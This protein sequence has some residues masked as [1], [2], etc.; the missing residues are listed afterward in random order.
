[1]TA[2]VTIASFE[3]ALK[4]ILV[5]NLVDLVSTQWW[6]IT[7][8]TTE[9]NPLMAQ[10][11]GAGPA[12]FMLAKLAL[13]GLAVTLLWRHRER[14]MARVAAVPM[15]LLYAFIGGS[16]LGIASQVLPYTLGQMG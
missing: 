11:L 12:A 14:R 13:V 3:K 7:G 4:A 2:L 5:L 1:M 8:V 10:A 16:H 6:V 15:A 9:A